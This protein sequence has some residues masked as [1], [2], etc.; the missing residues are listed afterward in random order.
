MPGR[1]H[2]VMPAEPALPAWHAGREAST[3]AF[4]T[5]DASHGPQ[6]GDRQELGRPDGHQGRRDRRR[7][8]RAGDK[9][10]TWAPM[11]V[12]EAASK[13]SDDA[14]DGTTPAP[15]S[16]RRSSARACKLHRGRRRRERPG[17]RHEAGRRGGVDRRSTK[18]ATPIK[19]KKDDRERRHDLRQQRP[20]GRQDHGRRVRQGRQGRRHHRRGGQEPRDRGRPSSRACSSTAATSRPTSSPTP[21]T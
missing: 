8:D 14:G 20:R 2:A 3:R 4:S 7:G 5:Q 12:K 19:G 9:A 15:S 11:L 21:T 6:R 10:R 13:T 16:P 18:L 17:P 1:Q